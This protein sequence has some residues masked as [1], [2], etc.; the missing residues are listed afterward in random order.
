MYQWLDGLGEAD[1][2]RVEGGP[3]IVPRHV[4][5][6]KRFVQLFLKLVYPISEK[7]DKK[8]PCISRITGVW[9]G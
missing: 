9:K 6:S 7:N 8:S 4:K 2:L 3:K 5:D 1:R